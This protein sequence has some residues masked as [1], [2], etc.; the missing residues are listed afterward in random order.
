MP[1]PWPVQR[2]LR[3]FA[4]NG[5]YAAAVKSAGDSIDFGPPNRIYSTDQDISAVDAAPNGRLLVATRFIA[6]ATQPLHVF[7]GW[8]EEAAR[9][10]ARK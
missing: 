1:R 7:V 10:L 3:S 4:G 5:V 6:P 8:K 2:I 9:L